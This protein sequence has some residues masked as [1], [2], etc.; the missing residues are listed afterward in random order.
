MASPVIAPSI[1][2]ADYTCFGQEAKR[3]EHAGGDWLH[4]DIMDGHFV[5]NI[6]FGSG[7]TAALKH[8]TCL[9]LDV[10]LMI[11]RPDQYVESFLQAGAYRISVHVEAQ[12]SVCD[13]LRWIRRGGCRA[14]IAFNPAT[15][16]STI[17][18]YLEEVDL[19]LCMTVVPGFGGQSFM[20]EVLD[21]VRYLAKHRSRKKNRYYIEVDGGITL[22]TAG[23]SA[24]AGADVFVAGTFLFH[25]KD[26]AQA[27]AEMRKAVQGFEP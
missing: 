10:H 16:C 1:L 3:A 24:K 2:A 4:V 5:P 8:S 9:P 6:S 21:K 17:E 26:M 15:D 18:P 7:V 23:A 14:G 20:P 11:E 13:T 25:A 27:V 12:H 22:E 19:V